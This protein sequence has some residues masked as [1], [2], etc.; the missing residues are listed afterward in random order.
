VRIFH[1]SISK[2]FY[3][4]GQT[5][6]FDE[7]LELVESLPEDQQE[8]LVDIVRRRLNEHGRQMLAETIR[9]ARQEYARGE[10][11]SGSVDDLMRELLE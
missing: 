11:R 3:M 6:T 1:F 10:V 4:S 7:V 9:E 8:Y 2:E 5:L